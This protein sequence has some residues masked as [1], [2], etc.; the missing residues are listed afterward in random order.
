MR[1]LLSLPF[2]YDFHQNLIIVNF[3]TKKFSH[4]ITDMRQIKTLFLGSNWEAL[5]TLKVLHNDKR[6]DIIGTITQPDKPVG[7]NQEIKPT[8]IKEYCLD[9]EIQV[10]HTLAKKSLYR[11][12]LEKFNPEL[13][14]CKSFGEILPKFFIE[15]PKF[16]VINVHYSLLPK[17]RGAVP[18]QKA[19]LEGDS[20][21]GISI[22]KMVRKLDAGPIISQFPEKIQPDDTNI[23][24]RKRLVQMTGNVLPDILEKWCAGK[25]EATKQNYAQATY[26]WEKDIAKSQALIDF[27]TMPA[28]QI[29][30]MVRAFVP[31]PVAW[32]LLPDNR[33]M[34]IFKVAIVND[35]SPKLDPGVFK[36]I[37]NDFMVGAPGG[38][39]IDLLDVQIEGKRHM[40]MAA[41]I[42]GLKNEF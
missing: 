5:E 29:D 18:I 17:Y 3:T 16:G 41:L 36:V 37:D 2:S 8:M 25:I 14:V 13:A 28:N 20:Q 6:F 10:F 38:V 12:A 39:V 35:P 32:C 31:W 1:E 23:S 21:T 4:I 11:E 24:L 40:D 33:R 19:I 7:R 27:K 9:Q 34:K 30:R 15:A 42:N 22:V 26:C